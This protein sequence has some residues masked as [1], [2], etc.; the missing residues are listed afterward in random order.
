M[1]NRMFF[2]FAVGL[3]SVMSEIKAQSIARYFFQMPTNLFPTASLD[4]RKDL[5]DFYKNGKT[6]V[7]P[8]VI[9]GKVVLKE[10]SDDYLL[11]QTSE[12]GDLQMKLL[13][14]NDTSRIIAL[15]HTVAAPLKDSRITFYSTSWQPIKDIIAPTVSYMDFLDKEKGQ[16]LGL[17]DR[18][19]EICLR[20]FISYKFNQNSYLLVAHSSLKD[21]IRSEIKKDFEPV[22]RDSLVFKWQNGKFISQNM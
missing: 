5:V 8:S 22:I 13:Q 11:L 16:A 3:L 21:D 20:I 7:M 10:L 12:S 9:G 2:M 17:A 18:F 4:S 14:Y 1:K 15:V 19:N 6:A